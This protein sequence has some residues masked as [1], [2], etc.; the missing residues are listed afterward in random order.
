VD[1]V[2]S[3]PRAYLIAR[4][5]QL[6]GKRLL[7]VDD[8][9]TN[10]RILKTLAENWNMAVRTAASGAEALTLLRDNEIFDAVILDMH[11]P[12][13]DGVMLARE[14]RKLEH[15]PRL[16]L[17][18]LS[19]LGQRDLAAEKDLFDA[20]LTKPAKPEQVLETLAKL[21]KDEAPLR[22]PTM[23]PFI[24]E[25][26]P[27]ATSHFAERVLLAEDNVVNQK[28]A[29]LILAKLGYRADLAANGLEVLDAVERL[30]YSVILMDVQMP[31][32]DGIEAAR[33][34]RERG[35]GAANRPFII[36]LTANA[37]Q[38][39]R[40][41]CMEAGMDDYITKPIKLEE[42]S[43]A[44]DRARAAGRKA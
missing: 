10:R 6:A 37:M 23:H 19:S 14:I 26:N 17:I 41:L 7:V 8:N 5:S 42:L 40:E 30:P 35:P 25:P 31:E 2:G 34:I 43:A 1:A 38:G 18:M 13:M 11:M 39:D 44:L 32:M 29:L 22:A 4:K 21:L 16:P 20:F 27:V 12:E 28:V 36:A 33:R 15:A 9:A 3:K 24:L